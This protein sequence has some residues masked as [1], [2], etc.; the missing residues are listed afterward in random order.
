MKKERFK[1]E[2]IENNDLSIKK[3]KSEIINKEKIDNTFVSNL[4]I[5]DEIINKEDYINNITKKIIEDK[6]EIKTKEISNLFN[7]L[8]KS[9][10][11]SIIFLDKIEKKA[12]NKIFFIKNE[13][14]FI[15]LSNILNNICLNDK[16]DL[17]IFNLI[18]D[19]SQMIVY[20]KVFLYHYLRKKNEYFKTKTLWVNL[21]SAIIVEKI[22]KFIK[23]L[24]DKKEDKKE[25]KNKNNKKKGKKEEKEIEKEKNKDDKKE[26]HLKAFLK[27]MNLYKNIK[28][29]KKVNKKEQKKELDNFT[30]EIILL[31]LSEIIPKMCLF[32]VNE[33][34]I[35]DIIEEYYKNKLYLDS[36]QL[37][38]LQNKIV[39]NNVLNKGISCVGEKMDL[40]IN[41]TIII[42]TLA[43]NYLKLNEYPKLFKLNKK[44]YK[45]LNKNIILNILSNSK[46]P[47]DKT[48]MFWNHCLKIEELK[49]TYNYKSIKSG[50]SI[51]QNQIKTDTKKLKNI[52]I[53]E[54]DL[55]RTYFIQ[56]NLDSYGSIKSILNCFLIIFPQIGYCQG[57]NC[58]V[59]FL[60][61]ILDQDEENTFYYFCGLILN[62]KY[63]EIFEDDF[64]SLTIFFNVFDNILKLLSPDIYYQFKSNTVLP[65]CFSS[66]WFITLFTE[67][68]LIFDKNNPSLLAIFIFNK[69]IFEGWQAIFNFGFMLMEICHDKIMELNKDKLL[70]YVMN[71]FD[72]ENIFDNENY[73]KCKNIYLK[74]E[75]IISNDFIN[76]LISNANF[77]YYNNKK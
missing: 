20:K 33:K 72:K 59:S 50:I 35:K 47:I 32:G 7:I 73:E 14:N 39:I 45:I 43:S 55:R 16:N 44:I 37:C 8:K 49:K 65:N 29:Y 11:Y 56:K 68:I 52:E 22:N 10:N 5:E 63:H 60:Y 38:Y 36:Q 15:H 6:E 30:K 4:Y 62:T 23:S 28:D 64:I 75:K 58:V 21:I 51:F 17:N 40:T 9:K 24:L 19:I 25:S 71:I 76:K 46:F 69:Y 67:Y 48:L 54:Q 1:K 70:S 31:T 2:M 34:I 74:N 61:Q 3:A 66:T 53:I 42:L 57:M 41:N 26:D 18:S 12:K 27:I 13:K 77:E